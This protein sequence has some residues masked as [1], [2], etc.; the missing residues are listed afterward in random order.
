[1]VVGAMHIHVSILLFGLDEWCLEQNLLG[2]AC[3]VKLNASALGS[4]KIGFV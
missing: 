4:S 2:H 1:M 3:L